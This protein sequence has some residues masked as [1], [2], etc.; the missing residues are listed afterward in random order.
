MHQ[1]PPRKA[2][3]MAIE[4]SAPLRRGG[5]AV[6]WERTARLV[7][8]VLA[9]AA[10]V[11]VAALPAEPRVV[12]EDETVEQAMQ[13]A[14]ATRQAAAAARRKLEQLAVQRVDRYVSLWLHPAPE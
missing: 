6:R 14:V 12:L 13:R 4:S 2:A 9:V 8:P 7:L 10:V 3:V 11:L 1:V 5:A